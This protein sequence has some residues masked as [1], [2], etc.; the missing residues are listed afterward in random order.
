MA[1]TKKTSSYRFPLILLGGVILGG[2]LGAV[3]GEKATVLKPLGDIFINLI[4]TIVVPLVFLTISSAIADIKDMNRLGKL[5][6]A[7]LAVF[8]FTGLIASGLM[9]GVMNAFPPAEGLKLTLPKAEALKTF[10]ISDQIV[11]A[12]TV[13]D[14][15]SIIS[16]RNML[17]LIMFSIF[18]GFTVGAMG[19]KAR[20]VTE[21]LTLLSNV[22]MKMISLLMLFAPVGLGAYFANL[23]GTHGPKLLGTYAK[24]LAIFFPTAFV[25][26][27]IAFTFYAFLA[28]RK[29][30]V[31]AF[32]KAIYVPAIT[33][34]ATRSSVATIPAELEAA[35]KIGVPNDI[36]RVVLPI[37]AT[38]HM[39]G[40]CLSCI[41][42]IAFLYGIFGM[43]FEGFSLYA[44]AVFVSV[45]SAVAIS[46]VPGGGV[47][48]ETLIVTMFGF[49]PEALPIVIMLGQLVDPITTMLNSTGDTVASMLI[50]RV[51]EGDGWRQPLSNIDA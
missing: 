41:F 27:F 45:L 9:V 18:F 1:D 4:F 20:K 6:G 46:G 32:W 8:V 39:D 44:F 43:P 15:A 23:V 33:A 12:F 28:D 22:V 30:G 25:Y 17:P 10:T 2:I 47:I 48:G 35:Q 7:T 19:E 50:A 49:P 11:K 3:F 34:V 42:K 36:S 24:A 5:L 29:G 31:T 21:G 16:R 37:G 40:S 13:D 14:F 51:V 38:A 26:F